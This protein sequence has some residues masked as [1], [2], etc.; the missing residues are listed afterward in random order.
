M[1]TANKKRF[2]TPQFSEMASIT[3][4]RLAW[5]LGVPMTK[6]ILLFIKEIAL[7]FP[8][9]E[10]CASCQDKSKCKLCAFNQHTAAVIQPAADHTPAEQPAKAA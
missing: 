4:R 7:L 6:A 8:S 10:V 2:Y 1:Y 5:F 3:I 9:S